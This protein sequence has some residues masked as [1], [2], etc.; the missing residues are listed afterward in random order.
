MLDLLKFIPEIDSEELKE[1]LE[2]NNEQAEELLNENSL[3]H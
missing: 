1:S 2:E 3:L